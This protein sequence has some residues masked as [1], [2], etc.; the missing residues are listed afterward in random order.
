MRF[1]WENSLTG[2]FAIRERTE[3]P[4]ESVSFPREL[5]LD[6]VLTGMNKSIALLAGLL[7]FNENIARQRLSWP[8]A[9]LELDDSV[10]RVWGE[11]AP[12]FE[13]DQNPDWTPD[14]HTVLILCD[15]RPYAVPIQSIE[16]PRQV[17]LQ[18]RDSAHWTGKMFSIDRVEFA[19]NISA[20]G[21]RF[22]EDLSFRVAIALLLCG[23]WRSSELVVERPKGSNTVFDEN[24]LIDLCASIG[25][26]LRV[27][28]AA[29]LEEM[30]VYAK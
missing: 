11:L 17:L 2:K 7:I 25:I 20:F 14:N 28:D 1:G 13:I 9:S 26:K 19:A 23:D 12:R 24:D 8:K 18:V 5:K 29:Q 4:S 16:K 21:R 3:F 10:R 30:L 6:L 22:A 15:D 27:L